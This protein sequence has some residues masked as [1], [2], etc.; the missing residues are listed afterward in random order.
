MLKLNEM[1]EALSLEV[2]EEIWDDINNVRLDP[3]K[4]KIFIAGDS[5]ACDYPHTGSP[6]RYPRTGWGQVLGERFNDKIQVVNCAISG[7]SSKSFLTEENF[8]YIRRNISEGDYLMIQFAH[9]DSKESDAARFTTPKDGTYQECIYKYINAARKNGA[10]PILATSVTRNVPEDE[11][12][13]PYGDALKAIGKDED[14]P[15]LDIYSLSNEHKQQNPD[16]HTLLYMRLLPHDARFTDYPEFINSEYYVPGSHDNT[17][18]NISGARYIAEL[19][20]SELKRLNH[21][22]TKYLI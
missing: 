5:T 19:A 14:I 11:T 9:N 6:N 4:I 15:V 2:P 21:P 20:V 16:D 17:H 22:L 13:A 3:D 12:L 7:R 10:K 18:L 8:D 1:N